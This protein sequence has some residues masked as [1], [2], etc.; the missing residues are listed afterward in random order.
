MEDA[1]ARS[2]AEGSDEVKRVRN[3]DEVENELRVIN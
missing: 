1:A 3:I 2:P